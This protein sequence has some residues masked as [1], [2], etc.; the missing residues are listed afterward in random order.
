MVDKRI[1]GLYQK[2]ILAKGNREHNE[3]DNK[4]TKCTFHI[5]LSGNS[6]NIL[7]MCDGSIFD[8]ELFFSN[9]PQL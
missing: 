3:E 2:N 4:K 8:G 6:D 9:I 7:Y 5:T 1:E